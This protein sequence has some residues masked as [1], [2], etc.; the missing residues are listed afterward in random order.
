[1]SFKAT[2]IR[3]IGKM[4]FTEPAIVLSC[5]KGTVYY[6]IYNVKSMNVKKNDKNIK[7]AVSRMGKNVKVLIYL[8]CN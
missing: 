7:K 1:M 2:K 8:F 4:D 3:A 5:L 6:K